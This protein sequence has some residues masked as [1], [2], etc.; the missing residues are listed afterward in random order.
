MFSCLIREELNLTIKLIYA[1][2]MT[3]VKLDPLT[4]PKPAVHLVHLLLDREIFDSPDTSLFRR[5]MEALEFS[6]RRH[7][8]D[9]SHCA[10]WLS[11]TAAVANLLRKEEKLKQLDPRRYGIGAGRREGNTR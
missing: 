9:W 8:F 11:A 7:A 6:A 4:L 1:S 5:L 3:F 10:Y 2:E